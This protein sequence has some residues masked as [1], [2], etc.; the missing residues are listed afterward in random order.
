MPPGGWP[1][2]HC[3][4][5]FCKL[6]EAPLPSA[7]NPPKLSEAPIISETHEHVTTEHVEGAPQDK[8]SLLF[9]ERHQ[10]RTSPGNLVLRKL[11]ESG[12]RVHRVKIAVAAPP[13]RVFKAVL[14][15]VKEILSKLPDKPKAALRWEE[16]G[17]LFCDTAFKEVIAW[18][19]SE[20][21]APISIDY[22]YWD[23]YRTFMFDRYRPDGSSSILD[24]WGSLPIA[25]MWHRADK[26]LRK[27]RD[28]ILAL[29]DEALRQGPIE[30]P[31]YVAVWPSFTNYLA[32]EPFRRPNKNDWLLHVVDTLRG[33]GERVLVKKW[34]GGGNVP[35]GTPFLQGRNLQQNA[36]VALYAKNNVLLC[37]SVS[38]EL[39]L[40]DLPVTCT[41]RS[42]FTGLGIFHEPDRWEDLNEPRWFDRIARTKWQ[43]WWLGRTF[44][45][46]QAAKKFEA[47]LATFQEAR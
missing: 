47:V 30:P 6:W 28:K 20:G 1:S 25:S 22:G 38:N 11:M 36:R 10:Y 32:R 23:H 40:W 39:T 29:K 12:W 43:N 33:Q 13:C 5:R 37:S 7:V 41:G 26:R 3:T 45:A 17:C 24:E 31:G 18:L 19:Y 16:H 8:G 14:A 4:A 35:E 42:W 46:H 15:D 27:Y 34:V 2:L 44:Y 9:L 21:I